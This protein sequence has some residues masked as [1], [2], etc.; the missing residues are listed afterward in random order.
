MPDLKIIGWYE[1]NGTV[2]VAC[3]AIFETS[4][5]LSA[6]WRSER[7]DRECC[8]DAAQHVE[9]PVILWSDYGYG[10]AWPSRTC[11]TCGVIVG[12]RSE[13]E[14]AEAGEHVPPELLAACRE[15]RG[16]S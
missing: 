14:A 8:K 5:E 12:H 2:D 13:E 3:T 1:Y 7:A 6:A 9:M 11:V 15:A 10:F 4:D 16:A